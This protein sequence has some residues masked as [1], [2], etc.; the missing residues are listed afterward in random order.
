V[1][2]RGA[3]NAD[4]YLTRADAAQQLVNL[5]GCDAPPIGPHTDLER[6]VSWPCRFRYANTLG[7]AAIASAVTPTTRSSFTQVLLDEFAIICSF[8]PI[9]AAHR[10][11][12]AARCICGCALMTRDS[13]PNTPRP[14]EPVATLPTAI[15]RLDPINHCG[16]SAPTVGRVI[17][18]V[19]ACCIAHH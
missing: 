4:D 11:A 6:W 18:P 12:S 15:R 13:L 10:K 14:R 2:R 17:H 16:K 7:A 1:L 9:A 19:M 3:G 8:L 5:L